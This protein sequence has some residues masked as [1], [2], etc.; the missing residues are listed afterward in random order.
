MD[1]RLFSDLSAAS[2]LRLAEQLTA[3]VAS[4]AAPRDLTSIQGLHL[5]ASFEYYTISLRTRLPL[6]VRT[7]PEGISPLSLDSF[8]SVMRGG[9]S[10]DM[11]YRSCLAVLALSFF[12]CKVVGQK[13][14][15]LWRLNTSGLPFPPGPTPR[16]V[17]GNLRDI[18]AKYPWLT[19]T[20][21][22]RRY[23]DIVHAR[24]LGQH[25][26]IVN[27]VDV[28]SELC[29]KRA[30]IYSDR[31]VVT[32]VELTGWDINVGLMPYADRW[33]QHRKIFQQYF[34]R[35]ASLSYRPVQMEKIHDLL[36]E[37]L[38]T[39]HD[40]VTLY[41]K[42]SGAVIMSTVYG[43]NIESLDD[44]FITLADAAVNKLVHSVFPGAMAVNA[45]PILRHLPAW[46]P[47]CHFQRFAAE[48]R[49]LLKEMQQI[50]FNF[51]RQNVRDGTDTKSMMAT[52]LESND[53]QGGSIS[54]EKLIKEVSTIAYIGG[55]ET[56]A[57]SLGAFFL[58]MATH[59]EIQRK[60]QDEIDS[61]IGTQRLPNFNDRPSL[62]YIEALY[63]E[64]MRWRPA[65]PLSLPR[66]TT[67]DD[68]YN[69][70]YIPKGSTVITN[71]WAMTHDASIYPEPERFNP[72][73]YFTG[74]NGTLNDDDRALVF[75]F[76]R[77]I[78]VGRHTAEDTIW[79]TIV[80]VLSVFNIAKAKDSKGNE[81]E[82]DPIFSDGL[83]GHPQP[84]ECAITVRSEAARI[85]VQD[86]TDV[87]SQEA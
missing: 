78:C 83:I 28:A 80:S 57:S 8:G 79:A 60:A 7:V 67:E 65:L 71:I 24:A 85:L 30:H 66:A 16:F 19:F 76:G 43:Y 45:F 3:L 18:P 4:V 32:M 68:I 87:T 21:W 46:F 40:F 54:Q 48:C 50:P 12:I 58:V 31:P 10:P 35:D 62:P 11:E 74:A 53:A 29:E 13:L 82:I 73:R 86:T 84:F 14:L 15:N 38:A 55:A 39:P 25:I 17:I 6:D 56:T 63:R 20:E 59:P 26:I 1:L 33:R 5:G 81:I 51:V 27:S 49:Q 77:R 9:R 61:V 22:G 2:N 37:L 72:D 69:G 64:I 75:G 34:R 36:R 47:G 42:L 52:L 70:Y 44:P 23:G 41:K